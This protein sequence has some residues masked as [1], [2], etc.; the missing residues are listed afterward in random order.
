M[1]H[2]NTNWIVAGDYA[3][4]PATRASNNGHMNFHYESGLNKILNAGYSYLVNGDNTAVAY[5]GIQN[6]PLHQAL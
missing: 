2:F 6:S 3:W 1:Y 5:T 4:D